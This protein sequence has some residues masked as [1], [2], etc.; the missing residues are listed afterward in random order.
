MRVARAD[1]WVCANETTKFGDLTLQWIGEAAD[2]TTTRRDSRGSIW[3][4]D[5]LQPK[6][7]IV[8]TACDM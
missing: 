6:R 1:G 8:V 2:E 4:I 5:W 3:W 7:R